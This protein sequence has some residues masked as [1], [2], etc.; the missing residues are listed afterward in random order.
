M[1]LIPWG[2]GLALGAS[3]PA[4]GLLDAEGKRVLFRGPP[5]ADLRDKYA[6]HFLVSF[7]G[8]RVRFG[9]KPFSR[10]PWLFDLAAFQLAPSVSAPPDLHPADSQRLSV[11]GWKNTTEPKLGGK[12]VPLRQYEMSR[13]LAIA[14]DAQTFVLGAEWSLRRFDKAG[15]PLWE[16]QGP[17]S[18]WGVNLATSA[19]CCGRRRA[20]TPPHPVERT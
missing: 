15:K 9:L 13:S 16:K 18:A 7:D 5:M 3:D 19:G 8:R 11:E 17:G 6:E 12:A 20:T 1:D 14:P 10:D 2:Q 4:F